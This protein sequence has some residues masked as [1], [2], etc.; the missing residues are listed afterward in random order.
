MEGIGTFICV[1]FKEHYMCLTVW[2]QACSF[3]K[4]VQILSSY[5]SVLQSQ[6]LKLTVAS[7]HFVSE[8]H[9]KASAKLYHM[10][11]SVTR[12]LALIIHESQIIL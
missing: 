8:F 10:H 9:Q 2:E 5:E 12:T 6:G 3:S 4:Q 7:S 11:F 1:C